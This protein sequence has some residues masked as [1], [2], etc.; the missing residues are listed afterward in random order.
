MIVKRASRDCKYL[1][2]EIEKNMYKNI[3]VS[4]AQIRN[5]IRRT[6]AGEEC[7]FNSWK[8]HATTGYYPR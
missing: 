6:N 8:S 7:Y 4:K 3:F 1:A 5:S 2:Y